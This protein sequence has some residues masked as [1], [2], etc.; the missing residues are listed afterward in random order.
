MNEPES[1]S[2]EAVVASSSSDAPV[3]SSSSETPAASSSSIVPP[4]ST[5]TELSSVPKAIGMASARTSKLLK[6]P[7]QKKA[8]PFGERFFSK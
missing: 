3:A 5:L 6:V 7:S 1:G 4:A 2:S 8:L